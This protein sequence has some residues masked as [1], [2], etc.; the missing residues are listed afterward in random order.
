MKNYIEIN[1]KIYS[2]CEKGPSKND[3]NV[4]LRAVSRIAKR[5]GL[6]P[7]ISANLLSGEVETLNNF[8]TGNDA[9]DMV[10]SLAQKVFDLVARETVKYKPR[11]RYFLVSR[12]INAVWA[13]HFKTALVY[14]TEQLLRA[15]KEASKERKNAN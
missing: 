3:M 14:S 15:T 6:T 1:A 4:F 5:R 11:S 7:E 8:E 13:E 10:D 12:V 9:N 2:S